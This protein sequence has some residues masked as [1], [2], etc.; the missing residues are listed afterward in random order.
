MSCEVMPAGRNKFILR[1]RI[2]VSIFTKGTE[3]KHG[4]PHTE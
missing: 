3:G 4:I 1:P 2:T